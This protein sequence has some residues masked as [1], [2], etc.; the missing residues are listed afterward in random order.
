VAQ[1][2]PQ[3]ATVKERLERVLYE[4]NRCNN[5]ALFYEQNNRFMKKTKTDAPERSIDQ[6]NAPAASGTAA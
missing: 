3:G 2:H 1:Q 5:A 4:R 6:M